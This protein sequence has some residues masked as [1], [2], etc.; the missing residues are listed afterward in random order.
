MKLI[1]DSGSTKIEWCVLDNGKVV[2]QVLT[3]GINAVLLTE[4]EIALT[5]GQQLVPHVAGL[6]IDEIYYYGAGCLFESICNN[7]RNALAG[8]IPSARKIVVDSDMLAAARA[9][10]GDDPGIVCILGTGSNSCYYDGNNIVDNVPS[11]GY[12]LGDEGSGAVLGKMLVGDALK[13]QMPQQL[14]DKFMAQYGLTPQLIIENVYRKP[15]ANRFLASL[16]P[17]LAENIEEPSVHRLVLNA[18]KAFFV[19]NVEN[20]NGYKDM[21]VHFVGSI[22]VCYREVIEEAAKA[23]YINIGKIVKSPMEGLVEYH[24][25]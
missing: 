1:A 16:S 9:V 4:E 21:P 23:L 15:G 6:P 7:V 19:R 12:I 13:R 5:I 22:A 10:C 18:F 20:Y 25:K 11:L 14:V 3:E 24:S 8:N 17:F 2:K